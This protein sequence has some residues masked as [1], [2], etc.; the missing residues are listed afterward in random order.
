[1][2]YIT[3]ADKKQLTPAIKA[4]AKKFKMKVTI[5]V[6]DDASL[7]VTAR[8]GAI[9]FTGNTPASFSFEHNAAKYGKEMQLF[10]KEMLAAMKSDDFEMS[11]GDD[12]RYLGVPSYYRNLN[13]GHYSKPYNHTL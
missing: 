5:S 12:S 1:M 6:K 9:E 10:A 8:S 3:Q 7:N 11:E 4:V 13:I 2:P